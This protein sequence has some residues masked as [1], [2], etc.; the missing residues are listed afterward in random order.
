MRKNGL[1][2]EQKVNGGGGAQ[3]GDNLVATCSGYD[4]AKPLTR[5]LGDV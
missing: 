2:R 5:S 1:T 3:F 4:P